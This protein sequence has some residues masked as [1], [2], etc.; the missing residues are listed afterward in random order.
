MEVRDTEQ[1]KKQLL[2][3]INKTIRHDILN[4]LTIISN[5]LEAY[6]DNKD[7]RLLE[8]ALDTVK[9][10]FELVENMKELEELVSAGNS[11]QPYNLREVIENVA[12][13]YT[14][15]TNIEGDCTVVADKALSSV[16][17]NIVGNAVKHGQAD[18]IDVS[19]ENEGDF[20]NLKIA[21]NGLGISPEIKER[22]FEEGFSGCRGRGL[23][24]YIVKKTIERYGGTIQVRDNHPCGTVFVLKLNSLTYN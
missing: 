3:L 9:R 17:D 23:G 5:S 22:I 10:S 12:E 21:D 7:E 19:I 4:D 2:S 6:K 18:R 24:L 20:C 1:N 16:I 11:L 13:R 8:N 14:L 15:K